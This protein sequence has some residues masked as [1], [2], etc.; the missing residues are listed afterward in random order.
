MSKTISA[1]LKAHLAEEVTTI[2][3]CWKVARRD[4]TEFFFT[5]HDVDIV[6]GGDTYE[7]S[8]GMLGSSIRQQ[9]SLT[10][11]QMEASAFLESEK[12]TEA[13]IQAGLFDLATLDV[14][15]VNY[16]D[17]TMGSL[18][19]GGGW[20]LGNVEIRDNS[21]QVE[22]RSKA[23]RLQRQICE[24]YNK[25]CRAVLGDSRCQVDL[26][27]SGTNWTQTG[28]VV[29]AADRQTFVT[30]ALANETR[31]TYGKVTWHTPASGDTW[32]GLNAGLEMEVKSYDPDTNT[33]SLFLPMP[34][35]IDTDDEFTIVVGCDKLFPTCRDFFENHLNFRGEPFIPGEQTIPMRNPNS[36]RDHAWGR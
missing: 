34:Y 1:A 23:E 8:S 7:A 28:S 17:L 35:A 32:D 22:I 31:L 11:D 30:S 12:I 21:F 10:V 25:R 19:L 5:D 13:D 3:T 6:F 2:A 4:G 33:L 9:R 14:F 27:Q 20:I 15:I 18:T 24:L 36:G 26:E 29:S 16:E